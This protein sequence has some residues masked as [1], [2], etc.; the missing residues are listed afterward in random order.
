MTFARTICR[1]I[2]HAV[3]SPVWEAPHDAEAVRLE[4]FGVRCDRWL[5]LQCEV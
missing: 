1:A 5:T 4:H 3:V 2:H